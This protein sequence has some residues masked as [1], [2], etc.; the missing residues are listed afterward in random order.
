MQEVHGDSPMAEFEPENDMPQG[1]TSAIICGNMFYIS[2]RRDGSEGHPQE[3]GQRT[4]EFAA[5]NAFKKNAM[6]S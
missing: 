4:A 6:F 5:R 1:L 3:E 2:V